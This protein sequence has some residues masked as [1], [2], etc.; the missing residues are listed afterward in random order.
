MER[1]VQGSRRSGGVRSAGNSFG[2]DALRNVLDII[3]DRFLQPEPSVD[4]VQGL[5][6]KWRAEED[7]W[8]HARCDEL[9]AVLMKQGQKLKSEK[10]Q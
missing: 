10:S 3:D 8:V 6:E 1:T 5:L 9:E 4:T 2:E 7:A